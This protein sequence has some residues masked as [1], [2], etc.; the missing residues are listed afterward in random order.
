MD[1]DTQVEELEKRVTALE[2]LLAYQEK[3][4]ADL[5]V[6][7]QEQYSL[8]EKISAQIEMVGSKL[9]E[10]SLVGQHTLEEER[11]PHY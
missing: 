4:I 2:M 1:K 10:Q 9:E 7:I 6:V 11:P 3:T 5:D 8:I